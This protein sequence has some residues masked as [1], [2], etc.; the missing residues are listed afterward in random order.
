MQGSEKL[1]KNGNANMKP[2]AILEYNQG[3]PGLCIPDA[4]AS[5][6]SPLER[7]IRCYH[8]VVFEVPTYRACNF[9]H[10]QMMKRGPRVLNLSMLAGRRHT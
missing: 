6:H 1:R 7:S 3:E 9:I 10:N 5:Y 2:T 8:K 4:L